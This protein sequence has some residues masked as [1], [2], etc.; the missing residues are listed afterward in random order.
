MVSIE[1]Y[2]NAPRRNILGFTGNPAI[3]AIERR[4]LTRVLTEHQR[5]VLS[6][7]GG[8]VSEKETFDYLLSHCYHHLDKGAAGGAHVAGA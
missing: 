3:E 1:R 8:V 6:V 2:R 4:T 7:G 5:A